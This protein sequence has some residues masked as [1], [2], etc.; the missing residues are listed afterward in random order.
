MH[1]N[2]RVSGDRVG[3]LPHAI[4]RHELQAPEDLKGRAA[5]TE[6]SA[7][8]TGAAAQQRLRRHRPLEDAGPAPRVMQSLSF[9]VCEKVKRNK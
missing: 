7:A 5:P 8:N 4:H 6:C 1:G 2:T 3:P 9:L